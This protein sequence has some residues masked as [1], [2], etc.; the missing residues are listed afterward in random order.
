VCRALRRPSR[1]HRVFPR[2]SLPR[3]LV[4]LVSDASF[5]S[6]RGDVERLSSSCAS[7]RSVRSEISL[8]CI[9]QHRG[10]YMLHCPPDL[11]QCSLSGKGKSRFSTMYQV[12]AETTCR[13]MGT[14][15]ILHHVS[16]LFGNVTIFLS[17]RRSALRVRL[18]LSSF[19]SLS[20]N[21]SRCRESR[22]LHHVT[23]LPRRAWFGESTQGRCVEEAKHH[24]TLLS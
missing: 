12:E 17:S 16:S 10:H 5:S 15:R 2:V 8:M 24:R 6:N 21:I 23:T 22:I 14:S 4:W 1:H 9:V 18:S 13:R 19:E 7:F 3:C 20:V 11:C